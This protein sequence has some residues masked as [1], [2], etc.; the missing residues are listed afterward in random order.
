MGEI[1]SIFSDQG[2][3][4][5]A[6]VARPTKRAFLEMIGVDADA[7]FFT[8]FILGHIFEKDCGYGGITDRQRLQHFNANVDLYTKRIEAVT[9]RFKLFMPEY[10]CPDHIMAIALNPYVC[11]ERLHL[12]CASKAERDNIRMIALHV[13]DFIHESQ[14][15]NDDFKM[16]SRVEKFLVMDRIQENI[17]DIRHERQTATKTIHNLQRFR[18]ACREVMKFRDISFGDTPLAKNIEKAI[19]SVSDLDRRVEDALRKHA[20]HIL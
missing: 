13:T 3:D 2:L 17:L 20:P 6:R 16:M 9:R 5:S 14:P 12:D 15:Q 10:K 1:V 4:P 18:T 8:A 19:V 7:N 11:R